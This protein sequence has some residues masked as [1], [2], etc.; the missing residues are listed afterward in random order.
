[1]KKFLLSLL[2]VLMLALSGCGDATVGVAVDI[3][4]VPV[5]FINPPVITLYPYTKDTQTE[6]IYGS[7]DFYASDA[8][9]YSMTVVAYNPRGVEMS[10]VTTYPTNLTG[11]IRGTIP[12]SI[13]YFT[14]PSEIN[15]Y[16]FSVYLTDSNGYTSNQ[17]VDRFYVP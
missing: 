17:A 1:M 5:V 7:I 3:P 4:I 16:T 8:D 14:F 10:R 11:A 13:D 2:V 6:Y 12:F 15:A 9:I